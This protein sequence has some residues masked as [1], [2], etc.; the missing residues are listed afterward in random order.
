MAPPV[1]PR[2]RDRPTH[3]R[4]MRRRPRRSPQSCSRRSPLPRRPPRAD[5]RGGPPARG[6]VRAAQDRVDRHGTGFAPRR[7]RQ[8]PLDGSDAPGRHR[9][10]GQGVTAAARRRAH[11]SRRASTS[12]P[13]HRRR[14]SGDAVGAGRRAASRVGVRLA[15]LPPGDG[16]RRGCGELGSTVSRSRADPDGLRALRR[17]DGQAARTVRWQRARS[18]RHDRADGGASSSRSSAAPRQVA[19]AVRHARAFKRGTSSPFRS[20]RSASTAIAR[21]RPCR[22]LTPAD[23]VRPPGAPPRLREDQLAVGGV[24]PD[25]VAGRGTRPRGSPAR[26]GRPAASGSRA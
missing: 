7:H 2:V 20:T 12:A 14:S 23:G 21:L 8:V 5:D 19:A 1:R 15:R 22:P 6:A 13:A 9:H 11:G 26:A 16:R 10:V 4:A 24:H 25:G 18:V 17:P 3:T